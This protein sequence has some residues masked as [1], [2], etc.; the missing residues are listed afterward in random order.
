[1]HESI[2]DLRTE[3]EIRRVVGCLTRPSVVAKEIKRNQRA[4]AV[5][6]DQIRLKRAQLVCQQTPQRC[7]Q[8]A[9]HAQLRNH[10][11]LP[12][13]IIPK[14]SRGSEQI[15]DRIYDA[16]HCR[17]AQKLCDSQRVNSRRVVVL[18]EQIIVK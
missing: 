9:L 7:P 17:R 14:V 2:V 10:S 6:R 16:V 5:S 4:Q 15:L 12:P 1:M 13:N 18:Q 11:S 8:R 3:R